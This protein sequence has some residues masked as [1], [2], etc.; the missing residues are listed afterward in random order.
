MK[1]LTKVAL[2]SAM[3]ISANAMAMQAMDDDSLSAT[4]GQ[5][6]ITITLSEGIKFDQLAIHDNGGL[7]TATTPSTGAIVL[8]KVTAAETG[9]TAGGT[10]FELATGGLDIVI[11]ANGGTAPVLNVAMD[12]GA[13]TTLN[14]G[15]IYVA[16]STFDGTNAPEAVLSNAKSAINVG[17]IT[18][19]DLEVNLQL[20][21]QLQGALIKVDSTITN[22]IQIASLALKS[23]AT[24]APTA[25]ATTPY[26]ST[27]ITLTDLVIN[28]NA[29]TGDLV[30]DLQIDPTTEGLAIK[31]L[32][33]LNV[34]ANGVDL[35]NG[36][37][38]GG[39]GIKNLSVGDIYV[40]GH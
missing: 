1:T 11:D 17:T 13:T 39:L 24:P 28:N 18:L 40:K 8:G 20:G 38:I 34:F 22:G 16:S 29:T 9:G 19:Q 7:T 33:T 2:V 3:A 25:P 37:S 31:G 27:A 15:D 6:G 5:D 35:G 36:A 32:G 10:A 30:L 4:T 14:I 23:N 12:F 21:S 26:A